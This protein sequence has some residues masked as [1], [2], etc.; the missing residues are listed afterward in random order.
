[1][2]VYIY[3]AIERGWPRPNATSP[4]PN[5]NANSNPPLNVQGH[6]VQLSSVFDPDTDTNIDMMQTVFNMVG[7]I[8]LTQTLTLTVAP[9][10]THDLVYRDRFMIRNSGV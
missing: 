7:A 8:I 9:T 3:A 4:I 6:P 5:R 10:L 2:S 1:M